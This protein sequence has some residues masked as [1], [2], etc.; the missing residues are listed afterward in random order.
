MPAL[1]APIT[2][3]TSL[4]R[5]KTGSYVE[6]ELQYASS[7]RV[8]ARKGPEKEKRLLLHAATRKP[9]VRKRKVRPYGSLETGYITSMQRGDFE[10][11]MPSTTT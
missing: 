6:V 8:N 11:R 4:N 2:A 9:A 10:F 7:P 5:V 3:I 1:G